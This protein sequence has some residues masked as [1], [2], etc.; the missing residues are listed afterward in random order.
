[1]ILAFLFSVFAPKLLEK[2]TMK[3]YA[4]RFAAAAVMI[5]AALKLSA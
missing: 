3:V 4:V 2:H 1:M 5:A